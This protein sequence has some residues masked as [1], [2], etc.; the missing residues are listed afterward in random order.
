MHSFGFVPKDH[1]L[2]AQD[3]PIWVTFE[4]LKK[5]AAKPLVPPRRTTE[6]DLSLCPAVSGAA[7]DVG[8]AHGSLLAATSLEV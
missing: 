7:L 8:R 1:G 2:K 5:G 4:F 3:S 6:I